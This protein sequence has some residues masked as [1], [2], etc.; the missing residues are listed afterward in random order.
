MKYEIQSIAVSP[1]FPTVSLP[2]R[3]QA[4]FLIFFTLLPDYALS[5]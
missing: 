2:P 3:Y 4:A 1:V 5:T